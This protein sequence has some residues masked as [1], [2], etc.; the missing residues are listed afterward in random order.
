ML[1]QYLLYTLYAE[2]A[3]F[4]SATTG[5]KPIRVRTLKLETRSVQAA[6][7]EFA[8]MVETNE[9]SHLRKSIA[10]LAREMSS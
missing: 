10:E 4:L 2:M 1:P 8:T 9:R 7:E 6:E 5:L 3:R